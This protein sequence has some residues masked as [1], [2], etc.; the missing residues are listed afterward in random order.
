[1]IYKEEKTQE[2]DIFNAPKLNAPISPKTESKLNNF[3][4]C[5]EST[6]LEDHRIGLKGLFKILYMVGTSEMDIYF[7]YQNYKTIV[8]FI[9]SPI[10][11]IRKNA[12]ECLGLMTTM[13]KFPVELLSNQSILLCIIEQLNT[14]DQNT[15][16]HS[17]EILS[18]ITSIDSL[19]CQLV[20]D[21]KLIP[22]LQHVPANIPYISSILYDFVTKLSAF[23]KSIF[24]FAVS[25]FYNSE[26]PINIK[27]SIRVLTFF[28]YQKADFDFKSLFPRIY[29]LLEYSDYGIIYSSIQFLDSLEISSINIISKVLDI[30]LMSGMRRDCSKIAFSYVAHM[31]AYWIDFPELVLFRIIPRMNNIAFE[32]KNKALDLILLIVDSN[33]CLDTKILKVVLPLIDSEALKYKVLKIIQRFWN[34]YESINETDCIKTILEEY[35]DVFEE[36]KNGEACE[37]IDFINRFL[38]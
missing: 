20:Y 24:E 32:V 26:N 12:I 13:K 22:I 9:Q 8:E 4:S 33:V 2:N 5:I 1:M 31:K 28:S 38:P 27:D 36:M 35:L 23:D 7:S 14:H 21:C 19:H 25:L 10:E 34:C 29:Q 6:D 3:L 15:I 30:A 16:Q 37:C 18:K 11:E 17:L